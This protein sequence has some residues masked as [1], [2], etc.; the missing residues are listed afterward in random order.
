MLLI[1]SMTSVISYAVT[2]SFTYSVTSTGCAFKAI[3][4]TNTSSGATSYYWNFGN[5][6]SA[7][8]TNPNTS[9]S[10]A[11]T[12]TVML[13]AHGAGGNDTTYATITVPNPVT[14]S[15]TASDSSICPGDTV[16]FTSTSTAANGGP[17]TNSWNINGVTST[18]TTATH[19]YTSVGYSNVY[20]ASYDSSGCPGSHTYINY[21]HVN[22]PPVADYTVPHNFYLCDTPFVCLFTST[23]TGASPFS[24]VW[25]FGDGSATFTSL[26]DTVS[27][28][29]HGMANVTDT[30]ILTDVHGCK[31]TVRHTIH[32]DTL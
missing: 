3:S 13:A 12:Y 7:T 28:L 16:T 25:H 17:V 30:L 6:H 5:G 24:Y 14:V 8:S 32:K 18:G 21:I 29:Y 1:L 2:A 4:F 15:F 19:V 11:G 9:Y 23:S 26:A 20:L 10:L 22:A 31:D 27:H